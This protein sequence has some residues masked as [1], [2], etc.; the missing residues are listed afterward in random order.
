MTIKS[1][2]NNVWASDKGFYLLDR[3]E[4]GRRNSAWIKEQGLHSANSSLIHCTSGSL[5]LFKYNLGYTSM[6]QEIFDVS[7]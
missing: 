3:A 2:E 4:K 1:L 7:R 6:A 5:N